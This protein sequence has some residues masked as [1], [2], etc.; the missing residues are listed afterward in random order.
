MNTK[1]FKNRAEAGKTL[2]GLLSQYANTKTVIYSLPRGG[3]VVGSEVASSLNV[4][5]DIVITRKVGHPDN[6][7]YAIASVTETGEVLCS[8]KEP[9]PVSEKWFDE[10]VDIAKK[11]ARRR[12]E[13]YLGSRERI[14]CK[15]K[16]AII[17]DDGVATGL[18]LILAI[19]EIKKDIPWKTIVAVPVISQDVVMDV[20]KEVDEFVCPIVDDRFRGAVG[21]YYESFGEVSDEEVI[22][23]LNKHIPPEQKRIGYT[24]L[25]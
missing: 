20:R 17:I 18:S 10:Q 13:T 8:P 4:P 3:V 15:G 7:E 25:D 21:A 1:M 5:L 23:I 6:P 16:N 22:E 11:E 9:S 12:R 14:S 19:R 24:G 2:A